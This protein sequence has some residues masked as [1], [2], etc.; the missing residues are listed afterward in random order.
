MEEI[1]SVLVDIH[2]YFMV[3]AS[4]AAS[5]QQQYQQIVDHSKDETSKIDQNCAGL[6]K[7]IYA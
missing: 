4:T 7:S 5:K 3:G 6:T 1:S 2:S